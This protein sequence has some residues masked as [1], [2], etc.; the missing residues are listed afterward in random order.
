MILPFACA[1]G[2]ELS[3]EAGGDVSAG[4]GGGPVNVGPGTT[5][6][7]GGGNAGT[8]AGTTGL[9]GLDGAGH[10]GGGTSVGSG[11][12]A[13]SATVDAGTAGSVGAGGMAGFPDGGDRD[14]GRDAGGEE[15]SLAIDAADDGTAGNGPRP[16]AITLSPTSAPTGQQMSQTTTGTTFNQRCAQDQ[17]LIG[18]TGTVEPPGSMTNWL[19]SFQAVCGSLS[20]AGTTYAVTTT[21]TVALPRRGMQ[22]VMAQMSMC[23]ANQV[24]VGFVAKSGGW[25]DQV[26]PVCAPLTIDGMSPSYAL[27]IGTRAQVA[28][29][30]G[31]PNGD[32]TVTF[33]CPAG[34]IAVGDEGR[35]SAAIEAF[36]LRCAVPT[37]VVR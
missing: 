3:L 12:A 13:G 37:L 6:T 23:P 21:Q 4:L 19:R 9:G 15:G 32:V 24:V 5:I 17:I 29:Y 8:R 11:G 18:F 14:A 26:L 36:G 25:I 7:V 22:Q 35:D 28:Q 30:V 10:G 31:G 2:V 33:P 34:Q 27:S 20:I 1:H 16:T